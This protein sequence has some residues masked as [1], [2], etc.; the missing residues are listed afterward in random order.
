MG[1]VGE[2]KSV[3]F[4]EKPKLHTQGGIVVES[5]EKSFLP[6]KDDDPQEKKGQVFGSG[7]RQHRASLR[8]G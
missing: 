6:L 3:D 7:G 8:K 5:C 1:G 2:G 4:F